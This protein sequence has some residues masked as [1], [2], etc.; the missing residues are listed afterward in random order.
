[1]SHLGYDRETGVAARVQPAGDGRGRRR[2][3]WGWCREAQ[4]QLPSRGGRW[5]PWK[6]F[7]RNVVM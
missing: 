5:E 6:V 3:G 1:M 4:A 2:T 7:E